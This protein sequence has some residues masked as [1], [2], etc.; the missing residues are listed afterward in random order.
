MNKRI[1]YL[2]VAITGVVLLI[3]GGTYAWARWETN[4]TDRT[5]VTFNVGPD[6]SCSANGGGDITSSSVKLAPANCTDS[7]Y[8][9]KRTITVNVTNSNSELPVSLDMWLNVINI[10]TNL[11]NNI[12]NNRIPLIVSGT[13]QSTTIQNYDLYIWLDA[14]ETNINVMNQ[15][16]HFT[17]GGS[18]TNQAPSE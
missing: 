10:D 3:I 11:L 7:N 12:S 5:Q 1:I 8:V 9:L 17:L 14:A 2:I 6:F 13:Y 16:F 4:N 18:C 15:N